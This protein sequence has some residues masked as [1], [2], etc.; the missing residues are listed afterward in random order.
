[1][2]RTSIAPALFIAAC[3][4]MAFAG[5]LHL[6]TGTVDTSTL[7]DLRDGIAQAQRL[8]DRVI[9][10]LHGPMDPDRRAAILASG[11][12]I[13][14]YIPDNAFILDTRRAR[15]NAIA[16][17]P[18]VDTV[19]EFHNAWK[20]DPELG[21]RGY[22]TDAN[23]SM[24]NA[25]R[26]PALVTLF[27]GANPADAAAQIA[28]RG[29]HVLGTHL[30]DDRFLL[31]VTGTENSLRSL[32]AVGSVKWIEPAP[33]T[34]LRSNTNTRWIIQTNQLNN[35]PI[36]DAGLRG[37]GQLIG[38]M[39]GRVSPTH[40]SFADP[41]VPFGDD[42]RKI[43]A[44]N[45]S[46]GASSHGT[47]VAGT[48]LGDAG[49]DNN[50]RGIAYMSRLVFNDIS[51][52]GTL[53]L[54][55]LV[56]HY[57]QGAAVHTNSW[58]DD[59]TTAY[60]ALARAID[61]FTWNN[62]DNIVLFAVT[63]GSFLRNPENA[64]N[65]LAVGA[66]GPSGSQ[67]NH[68][69]GGQGPTSDGRRKPEIYAPG[70]STNSATGT[71]CATTNSSGTSM[72]S[73]A[74]AGAA[75]LARQYY[76][77]GFYPTGQATPEDAF[78]PSGALLRATLLNG[79]VDMTGVPGY[80]S[81]REGWG[82]LML[83]NSLYFDGQGRTNIIRDV[84]NNSDDALSTGD[85]IEIPFTVTSN[86]E[87]VRVTLVWNDAPAATNSSFTPVN[88][89]DLEVD[90]AF[91]ETYLGN[92]FS[93][94]ISVT[95]GTADNLNNVEMVRLVF[96][97]PGD[98]VARVRA[99]QVNVG[100]QGYA[101]VIT[102]AVEENTFPGCSPADLAEPYGVLNFFDL[103]AYL[104]LYNAGDMAADLTGDGQLN[105][106]DVSTYLDLYNAGCP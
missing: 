59:G 38:I 49:V 66:T 80:P 47:H 35:T 69:T 106:F 54:N 34:T 62:D 44:Y 98:Y 63:N 16:A 10:Q 56:Q 102:G 99:P 2:S 84:R 27:P 17:L 26:L 20:I 75:A 53:F 81:N 60:N 79:T 100:A 87:E 55:R 36:Y 29:V 104:D 73:P 90:D 57:N 72:A 85:V 13:L 7:P 65:V 31:E 33:E 25:G 95:G 101:V 61:V 18:F 30:H 14:D 28:E 88:N 103:A 74:V 37:E 86:I 39:D 46:T 67:Q 93:G 3:A 41:G 70:C 22:Q 89:L 23:R 83:N 42:H 32:A 12:R 19:V 105:F 5:P 71:G 91:G 97:F 24:I 92:M 82:R 50:T 1:M 68:C 51:T 11:A 78:V 6:K 21:Q 77:E 94:G 52:N 15:M 48:A 40:C 58:G 43:Q 45:T 64:K 96:P 4:G 8:P 76:M 9:I